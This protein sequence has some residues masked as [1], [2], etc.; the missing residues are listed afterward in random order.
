MVHVGY[1]PS[2]VLGAHRK[3]GDNW[4]MLK[5]Q[6]AGRMGGRKGANGRATGHSNGH[7]NDSHIGGANGSGVSQTDL[8]SADGGLRVL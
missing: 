3:L 4:K 1:E 5:W 2:A 6:L 8:V 7:G